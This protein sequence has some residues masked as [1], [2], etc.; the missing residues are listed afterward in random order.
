MIKSGFTLFRRAAIN[1]SAI[2]GISTSGNSIIAEAKNC[3]YS[4]WILGML[5]LGTIIDYGGGFYV[6]HV[7]FILAIVFLLTRKRAYE[8]WLRCLPDM[9]IVILIPLAITLIQLCFSPGVGLE[10]MLGELWRRLGS[11]S[12]FLFF[13]LIYF[14]GAER[15]ARWLV[16]ILTMLAL[17]TVLV[18]IAHALGLID[19]LQYSEFMM[20]HR[21]ALFGTDIRAFDVGVADIGLPG[22]GAAQAFPVGFS[23]ALAL[24]PILS[25]ILA[26]ATV[27]G[28]QRGQ[29]VGVVLAL[30]FMLIQTM[31]LIKA[32]LWQIL[33]KPIKALNVVILAVLIALTGAV[34]VYFLGDVITLLLYKY[35]LFFSGQDES[36]SVRLGHIA[37]YLECIYLSPQGMIWGFGPSTTIYNSV[38]GDKIYMTE[39]VVLMYLFWYGWLY[40]FL[41][42]AWIGHGMLDLL[43]RSRK[44][45]DA[46]MLTACAVLVITGNINPVMLTPLAFIFLALLRT[47]LLELDT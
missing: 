9:A 10:A 39:M 45:F 38:I 41:F 19:I 34:A 35:E 46:A 47:R 16:L 6:K 13:P 21:L 15:T 44:R 12:Y 26:L 3:D 30:C 4:P 36:S 40:T 24:Y 25:V 43:K 29:V 1:D 18:M 20:S 8:L 28:T 33:H 23:L 17:M 22:F 31:V 27:L 11:P 32:K 7:V 14:V 5:L 2:A 42:Y 37:G